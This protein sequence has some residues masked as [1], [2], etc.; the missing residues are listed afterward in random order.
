MATFDLLQPV[1]DTNRAEVILVEYE[2]F[3][4][5]MAEGLVKAMSLEPEKYK[6]EVPELQGLIDMS[7]EELYIATNY[8][9]AEQFLYILYEGKLSVEEILIKYNEIMCNKDVCPMQ[10]EPFFSRVVA[11]FSDIDFIKKIIIMKRTH[12]TENEAK[13]LKKLFGE[14]NPKLSLFCGSSHEYLA[15]H[16]EV[17]TVFTNNPVLIVQMIQDAITDVKLD[18]I[19]NTLFVLRNNSET[20]EVNN[21]LGTINY[22]NQE[23][24]DDLA[25][26]GIT[27]V[28][29]IDTVDIFNPPDINPED[30]EPV[31]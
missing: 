11:N 9:E 29:H 25:K 21:E 5:N 26:K 28:A 6:D 16:P 24:Y 3:M 2:G 22:K 27:T 30:E 15:S 10:K 20:I 7:P 18:R 8:F 14:N 31:G 13:R 19:K 4:Q 1:G 17:T 23:Y 12:Y